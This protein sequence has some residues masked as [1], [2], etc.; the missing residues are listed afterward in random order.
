MKSA[1]SNAENND[2]QKVDTLYISTLVINKG[3][4]YKR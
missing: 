1:V 2:N 4:V 3:I